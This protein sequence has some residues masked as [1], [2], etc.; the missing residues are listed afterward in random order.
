MPREKT[1]FDLD[2][3]IKEFS[4]AGKNARP[5]HATRAA[6]TRGLARRLLKK[7]RAREKEMKKVPGTRDRM[8]VPRPR[9]RKERDA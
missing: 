2:A 7:K 6:K 8:R 4:E 3:L 5:F 1:P 9:K